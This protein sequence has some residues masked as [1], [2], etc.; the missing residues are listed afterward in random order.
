[1]K[2][3]ISITIALLTLAACEMDFYRSDTMTSA[4]LK[5]D[6]GAAVYTTDGIYSM[7]KD[8]CQYKG[9]TY[10]GNTYVRHYFQMSE[11][12]G[13]NVCLSGQTS[14]PLCEEMRYTDYSTQRSN[15]YMWFIAYKIIYA[16]NSNIEAIEPGAS[17]E[18]D[19]ILGENYFF[20]A[21]AHLH[22]VTLYA[23]PYVAGRDKPGVVLRKSTDCSTTT[24]ATVGEIY[25]QIVEDLKTAAQYLA[26]GSDRGDHGYIT[27]DAAKG[28]LTRVYLY[29]E[30]NQKCLDLCNEMLGS[31]PAD[32]LDP[33]LDNYFINARTSKETL[34]CVAH[35]STD[36]QNRSSI[37]SMYYS[38]DGTGGTGW[39]EMYW[40][41][42]LMELFLRYPQDKRF[43]AYFSIYGKLGDGTK[44]VHW[45][46]DDG[47]NNFRSNAIVAGNGKGLTP[48]AAGNITFTYGGKT[49][50]TT[51]EL[52]NGY[53]AY[54]ITY[55]GQ[56]TQVY[57]R[58]NT[59]YATGT[60]NTYPQY[61]MSKFSWQDGDPMLSSPVMI[62]WAE[63]ILNR[64]EANAKLGNDQ[65]AIDDVNVIRTRAGLTGDAQM[66]LTNYA[67]RGYANVLDVV[68]DERRMEL[69]FEGHRAFD[70]FRN[71]KKMDR[72][73]AGVQPWEV[74]DWTDNRIPYQIP[75]DE[76]ITSGIDQNPR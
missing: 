34:W 11:F 65:K 18:S 61:Y 35:M 9:E 55:E 26:T 70:V 44:M 69:C 56:K 53:P 74:V 40:S 32:K 33:D 14:D 17:S 58:D 46:I 24:R 16:A 47:V 67:A 64:A 10:S 75:S 76:I 3:I 37:G 1:M 41:D 54:F 42:P 8:V 50:T 23:T 72:R 51:N 4:Q 66:S 36:T 62:R 28:L 63:V 73:F 7:F 6:P 43:N 2:K 39:G 25:D 49:Y 20:R 19:H 21:I 22:L 5:D 71:K 52:V 30:E 68:L 29:M 15:C 48:N 60:R 27:A 38:T 57:I 12:R 59:D 13:D 45:P 31:N